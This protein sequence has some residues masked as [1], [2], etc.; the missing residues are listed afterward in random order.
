MITYLTINYSDIY[1]GEK[2][3]VTELLAGIS[4]KIIVVVMAMIN[5]ELSDEKDTEEVQKRFHLK[6]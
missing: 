2:P 5:A 4:S 1:P 3:T 6:L